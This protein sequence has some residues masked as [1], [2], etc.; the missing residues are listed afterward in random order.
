M[1]LLAK[2]FGVRG[3]VAVRTPSNE[4][5]AATGQMG[6]GQFAAAGDG[7]SGFQKGDH[8]FRRKGTVRPP[9]PR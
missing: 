2:N 9:Q 7:R 1:L 6:S 5:S 3:L 8:L 4:G